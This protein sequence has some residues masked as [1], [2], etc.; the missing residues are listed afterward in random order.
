[1]SVLK[2]LAIHNLSANFGMPLEMAHEILGFCF[3][4][5]VTAVSRAVHK[6]NMAEVVDRF[7]NAYL[8]RAKPNGYLGYLGGF[9]ED[10]D[11]CEHW[12]ICLSR[13]DDDTDNAET[14]FQL[15]SCRTCGNYKRCCT[16][17]PT[18]EQFQA[19]DLQINLGLVLNDEEAEDEAAFA[20][21]EREAEDRLMRE[22]IPIRMRCYC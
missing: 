12:G 5:T 8:S 9:E 22:V 15:I 18:A 17:I 4:D 7:D 11:T 2:Q 21:A 14:Q 10:P 3:Y 1:M 16:Y 20:W 13:A 6:A 19:L